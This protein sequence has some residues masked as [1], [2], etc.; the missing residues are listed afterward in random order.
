MTPG[1]AKLLPLYFYF[2]CGKAR[3]ELGYAPRPLP[4]SLRDAYRF[5]NPD[6]RRAAA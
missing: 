2:D 1:Q 4:E 5:W 3:R 6:D